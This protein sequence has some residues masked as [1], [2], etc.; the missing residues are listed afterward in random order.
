MHITKVNVCFGG[1]MKIIEKIISLAGE[2]NVKLNEPMAKHTT[3]KIGGAA[4]IFVTPETKDALL[5]IIEFCKEENIPVTVV[6][7]GSNLLVSDDGIDGVVICTEK[8]NYVNLENNVITS[9]AGA[10]LA[11]VANTA[12]RESLTGLEFAAGIPGTVG[13]G[14]FMNAGAYGGELKDVIETVTAMDKDGNVKVF[15]TGDCGFGY[16]TSM[17]GGGY[18]ILEVTFRLKKGNKEEILDIMKDLSHRR[19]DKQP[20]E[21]PSAGST[22]KRPKGYFAGKLIEDAGLKGFSVGGAEVSTKHAGFVINKGD[23]TASDIYNLC[24]AVEEKILEL[25]ERKRELADQILGGEQIG[26]GSSGL[27]GIKAR[28]GGYLRLWIPW[29]ENALRLNALQDTIADPDAIL[30]EVERIYASL[31]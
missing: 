25:Q 6:G 17:F 23:A 18:V 30:R 24:K 8:I 2:T 27:S 15:K 1:Y 11:V 10:F 26:S 4:D 21:Y 5:G 14:T 31:V 7:N 22:F 29:S 9:G 19:R 16:R 3:F 13:G 28:R 12:A 20:L